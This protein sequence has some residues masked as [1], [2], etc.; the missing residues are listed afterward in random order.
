[1]TASDVRVALELISSPT[2]AKNSARFFKTGPDEY[3]EGDQFIG[4]TVP[5]QR[6]VA[7]QSRDLPLPE[8][9]QLLES[10]IH[11]HRLTALFI[12]RKQYQQA[13]KAGR[14][15][16]LVK[17]YIDELDYVNNWDLVDS[18][19]P[20]ILG[21]WLVTQLNKRASLDRLA[22]SS[23]LWRQ[24]VSILATFPLIRENQF[25][26]SIRL[27]EQFLSHPHDLIHKA[28]G[29]MLREI[30]KRDQIVLERFLDQYLAIMPR[31]M[32]RYAVEKFPPNNRRKYLSGGH[33]WIM[34]NLILQG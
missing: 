3:G 8:L 5:E 32:L 26:E 2:R 30:G 27:A 20:Y 7:K 12:L 13:K 29:W 24:R 28:V 10:P 21:D 22:R 18:S 14:E 16:D 25:N 1:M 33:K 34:I 19:A 17:F 11:E 15:H 6:R 4:I 23:D 31:T 9:K